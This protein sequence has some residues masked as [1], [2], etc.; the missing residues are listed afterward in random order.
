MLI[1]T[2]WLI[3]KAL[4]LGH[5]DDDKVNKTITYVTHLQLEQYHQNKYSTSCLMYAVSH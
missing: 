1:R 3:N 2:E 4:L 5:D